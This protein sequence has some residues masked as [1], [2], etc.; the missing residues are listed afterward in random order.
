M[1]SEGLGLERHWDPDLLSLEGCRSRGSEAV[2]CQE[3]QEER[4]EG[5]VI[6]TEFDR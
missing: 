3:A 6:C 5:Q 2:C 1:N 4:R